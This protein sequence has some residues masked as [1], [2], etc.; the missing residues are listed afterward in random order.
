MSSM[1]NK[2]AKYKPYIF[3]A[4]LL[5]SLLP[6]VWLGRYNYPTGDDYYYGVETH[7]AW[8]QTGNL[9]EAFAAACNGVADLCDPAIIMRQYFLPSASFDLPFSSGDNGRMDYYILRPVLSVYTDLGL[10]E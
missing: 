2:F 9:A 5:V 3:L 10:S 1:K 4:I 7:L 8:Q 6:L